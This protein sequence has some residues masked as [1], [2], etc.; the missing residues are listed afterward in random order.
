MS[1]KELIKQEIEKRLSSLWDLIPEGEKVLKDDFTKDNANNLGKYT[2]LESLL[3]F[4]DS[5][6]EESVS[7][8]KLEKELAETYLAVF[9]KKYPILPTP[10][11]KQKA[12]FK[13]F[14]NKCQ[15]EFGLKEFGI[16]PT[17]TK[18]FEKLTLLWATWGAEHFEGLGKSNQDEFDKMSASEDLEE[19]AE[20]HV[21]PEGKDKYGIEEAESNGIYL[22]EEAAKHF[23]AGAEWMKQQM[24]EKAERWFWYNLENFLITDKY[25]DKF[26][27]TEPAFEDF[28]NSI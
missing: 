27:D 16:H 12:D 28:K 9:D 15:Q 24:I 8:D 26:F 23:K 19:A 11:G 18:L 5:I 20:K 13:N 4:I 17:Q 7:E 6:S 25:G 3:N 21:F 1:D 14:L 2:E 10:K 22:R